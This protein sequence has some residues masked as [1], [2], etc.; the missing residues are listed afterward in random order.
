MVAFPLMEHWVSQKD[1]LVIKKKCNILLLLTFSI[2]CLA[3]FGHNIYNHYMVFTWVMN[4]R[5][6][7][8]QIGTSVWLVHVCPSDP[9]CMPASQ[10]TRLALGKARFDIGIFWCLLLKKKTMYGFNIVLEF[11][12]TLY[13]EQMSEQIMMWWLT[14]YV[15][16]ICWYY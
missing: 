9:V 5:W 7:Q 4:S 1:V 11:S 8:C 6:L 12:Q 10:I 2:K 15:V 13:Y 3:V 16:M 14:N